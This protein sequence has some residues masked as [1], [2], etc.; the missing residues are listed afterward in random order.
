MELSQTGML[1]YN[2]DLVIVYILNLFAIIY[3]SEKVISSSSFKKKEFQF[4][5]SNICSVWL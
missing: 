1:S 2:I 5:I 4:V 3:G